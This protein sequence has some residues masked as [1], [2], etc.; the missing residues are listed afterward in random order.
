MRKYALINVFWILN[1]SYCMKEGLKKT[2]K[3]QRFPPQLGSRCN[4]PTVCG[5]QRMH[6]Q[7]HGWRGGAWVRKTNYRRWKNSNANKKLDIIFFR[8][9]TNGAYTK[10]E[11]AAVLETAEN[12]A[13]YE[14]FLSLFEKVTHAFKDNSMRWSMSASRNLLCCFK[15]HKISKVFGERCFGFK[16]HH[17]ILLLIIVF[18]SFSFFQGCMNFLSASSK[19]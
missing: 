8:C 9:L 2:L 14:C 19:N 18:V 16:L 11:Q 15:M 13:S 6:R 17:V 12:I 5:T 4:R 1:G 10:E 7:G 3:K